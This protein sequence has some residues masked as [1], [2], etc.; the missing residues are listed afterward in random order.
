[1]LDRSV[2]KNKIEDKK[3]LKK[4]VGDYYDELLRY[5]KEMR[6]QLDDKDDLIKILDYYETLN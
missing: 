4:F 3:L 5:S 6:L 1:L 2:E